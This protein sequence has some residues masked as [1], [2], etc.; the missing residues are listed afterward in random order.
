MRAFVE[1]RKVLLLQHDVTE[2]LKQI[3]DRIGGHDMQ[4]NP[5]YDALENLPD[6]KAAQRKWNDRDWIGFKTKDNPL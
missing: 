6:E 4:L 3:R 5:I 2:Q 1:V